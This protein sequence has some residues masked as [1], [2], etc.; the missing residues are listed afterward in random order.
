MA[1]RD[2]KTPALCKKSG[3]PCAGCMRGVMDD[4]TQCPNYQPG[5]EPPDNRETDQEEEEAMPDE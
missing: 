5:K 2:E 3:Q 4:V 1:K